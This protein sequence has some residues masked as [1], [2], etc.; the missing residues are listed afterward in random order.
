MFCLC[1]IEVSEA[2]YFT[3]CLLWDKLLETVFHKNGSTL[4]HIVYIQCAQF[5]KLMNATVPAH[6]EE[7]C[8]KWAFFVFPP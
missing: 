3:F 5:G 1:D 6:L 2:F 7:L 8:T 4:V